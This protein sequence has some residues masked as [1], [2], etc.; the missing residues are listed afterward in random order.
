MITR[1]SSSLVNRIAGSERMIVSDVAGTTR[2]PIDI[3]LEFEGRRL[4]LV[5]TAG[6]R[7]AAK[8]R[9]SVEY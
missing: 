1:I 7:R 9:E 5:D 2:D 8:V 3:E 4:R 6:I